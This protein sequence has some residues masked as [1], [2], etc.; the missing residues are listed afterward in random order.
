MYE[1]L[2]Q[3]FDLMIRELLRVLKKYML[4][5][6]LSVLAVLV[7]YVLIPFLYYNTR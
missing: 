2:A 4:H 6:A 5:G 3:M 7:M 1:A